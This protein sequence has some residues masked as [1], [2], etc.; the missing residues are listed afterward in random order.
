MLFGLVLQLVV[1]Y[2]FALIVRLIGLAFIVAPGITVSAIIV[3]IVAVIVTFVIVNKV[4]NRGKCSCGCGGCSTPC[5][6]KKDK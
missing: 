2:F 6:K 5:N 3:A 1:A 4:K